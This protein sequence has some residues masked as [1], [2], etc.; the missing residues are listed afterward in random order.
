VQCG[1][2]LQQRHGE[3]QGLNSSSSSSSSSN[4]S[5][6][7]SQRLQQHKQQE[8][9]SA[10]SGPAAA[11]EGTVVP[12]SL[13]EAQNSTFPV[14]IATTE[15]AAAA[16]A[17]AGGQAECS[18]TDLDGI[19][20]G[21]GQSML[22]DS[23]EAAAQQ[24]WHQ[25]HTLLVP[26]VPWLLWGNCSALLWAWA[27]ARQHNRPLVGAVG[28]GRAWPLTT[29]TAS[30]AEA[31]GA[32]PGKAAAPQPQPAAAAAAGGSQDAVAG[33][34]APWVL[35]VP[36]ALVQGVV[37]QLVVSPTYREK[38][39][40]GRIPASSLWAAASVQASVMTHRH[41]RCMHTERGDLYAG[42]VPCTHGSHA[43][44]R[45]ACGPAWGHRSPAAPGHHSCAPAAPGQ[46]C[47]TCLPA[48]IVHTNGNLQYATGCGRLFSS[49]TK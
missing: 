38:A 21:H 41:G 35:L 24:A 48:R 30:P 20:G 17:V 18:Q 37:H 4:S 7:R 14:Q 36:R 43:A 47:C 11:G 15:L 31:A 44:G 6:S 10:L 46:R 42:L 16:A 28:A 5:S 13:S 39:G 45:D 23:E 27:R 3:G 40:E 25:L 49:V 8:Q 2:L 19:E 32:G 29:P 1:H 33:G 22:D 26:L 34:R 12:S 9:W